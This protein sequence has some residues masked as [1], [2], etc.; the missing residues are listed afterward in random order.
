VYWFLKRSAAHQPVLQDQPES[1]A[2]AARVIV[3]ARLWKPADQSLRL[4][5]LHLTSDRS[6]N[7]RDHRIRKPDLLQI[8]LFY[9]QRARMFTATHVC[10][11]NG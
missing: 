10:Q 11:W 3:Q 7:S 5:T 4:L 8:G 9:V 2:I 1:W 6:R